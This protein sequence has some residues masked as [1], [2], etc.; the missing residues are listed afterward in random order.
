MACNQNITTHSAILSNYAQNVSNE[1][2]N[3]KCCDLYGCCAHYS[4][5]HFFLCEHK[6]CW[7]YIRPENNHFYS[8]EQ[9]DHS[10][11]NQYLTWLLFGL[12]LII[13]IT[14]VVGNVLIMRSVIVHN[15]R[16]NVHL[17]KF[18][19]GVADLLFALLYG[20]PVLVNFQKY[21]L[22][23]ALI[24]DMAKEM[25]AGKT[26]SFEKGDPDMLSFIYRMTV[27]NMSK[28][29]QWL[30]VQ[31]LLMATID[32]AFS[33]YEPFTHQNIFTKRNVIVAII[34]NWIFLIS[35]ERVL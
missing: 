17:F 22:N 14:S 5:I 12:I 33:L 23:P 20:L 10:T 18:F 21:V 24:G 4:R 3:F 25:E 35:Y 26:N 6:H 9:Q 31:M 8:K 34:G 2:P 29:S 19:L 27:A 15:R 30:S 1:P 16:T 13:F 28:I 32:R 7:S 11:C